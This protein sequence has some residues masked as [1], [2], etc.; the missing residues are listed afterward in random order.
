MIEQ[1]GTSLGS[2]VTAMRNIINGGG[3]FGLTPAQKR[4]LLD[5]LAPIEEAMQ[6]AVLESH[7]IARDCME[8]D[9]DD[10]WCKWCGAIVCGGGD[11]VHDADCVA[12][13]CKRMIGESVLGVDRA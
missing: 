7:A 8:P 4:I 6:A 3:S 13:R 12:I 1:T 11:E 9:G 5:R 10:A 2:A